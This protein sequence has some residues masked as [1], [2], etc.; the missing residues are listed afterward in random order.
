MSKLFL[1]LP[2]LFFIAGC[3]TYVEEAGGKRYAALSDSQKEYLIAVSRKT[4][5]K[6]LGKRLVTRVECDYALH[7]PPEFRV[8]YRGDRYGSAVI[9]WRTPGRLLEFHYEDDLSAKYPVCS[10]A[11]RNI[12]PEERRIQPDKSIRGR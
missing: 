7:N 3:T 8:I 6:H 9:L 5:Y 2:L 11:T 4:L 10:F 1:L 12:P